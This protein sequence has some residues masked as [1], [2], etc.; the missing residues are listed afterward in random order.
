MFGASMLYMILES[1]RGTLG[2]AQHHLAAFMNPR[3]A[4]TLTNASRY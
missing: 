2:L 3:I 1:F 4:H